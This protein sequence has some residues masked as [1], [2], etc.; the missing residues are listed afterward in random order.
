MGWVR[1][2]CSGLSW[3]LFV[4]FALDRLVS[5][6]MNSALT[7]QGFANSNEYHIRHPLDALYESHLAKLMIPPSKTSL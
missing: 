5:L 2:R 7:I 6:R 3:D 4:E 1:F